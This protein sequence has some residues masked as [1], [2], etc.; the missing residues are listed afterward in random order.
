ML[1]DSDAGELWTSFWEV[2]GWPVEGRKGLAIRA[3]QTR[4]RCGLAGQLDDG[5]TSQS[6]CCHHGILWSHSSRLRVMCS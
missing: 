4:L 5:L 2:L 3:G 6:G 1:G